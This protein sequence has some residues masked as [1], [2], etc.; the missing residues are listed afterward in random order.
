[1]V[2]LLTPRQTK[3]FVK[4]REETGFFIAQIEH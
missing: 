1:M 3:R 4:N 2:L